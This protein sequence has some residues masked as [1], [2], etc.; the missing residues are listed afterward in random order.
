MLPSQSSV[1]LQ[2][3]HA[4]EKGETG[5]A[6]WSHY[7]QIS[8]EAVQEPMLITT[9]EAIPP[10]SQPASQLPCVYLSNVVLCCTDASAFSISISFSWESIY[11][12]L[13]SS[14]SCNWSGR[15]RR[16]GQ[17]SGDK[18]NKSHCRIPACL[19]TCPPRD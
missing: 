2:N 6:S 1:V 17:H 10:A 16:G 15:R 5:P 7:V 12:I 19:P 8:G 11:A 3:M 4:F 14:S 9:I 18:R 13:L